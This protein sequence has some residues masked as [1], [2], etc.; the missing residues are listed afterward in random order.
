LVATPQVKDEKA[1]TLA[2]QRFPQQNLRKFEI[3]ARKA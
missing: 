3:Q 1:L 2:Q